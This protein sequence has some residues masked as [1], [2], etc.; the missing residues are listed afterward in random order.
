M[1]DELQSIYGFR[2]ADVSLFRA[3]RDELAER[4]GSLSLTRNFRGRKPLLDAVNAVFAQRFGDGYAPLEA[5]R[6]Q[7]V[8]SP[9]VV[10]DGEGRT[11]RGDASKSGWRDAEARRSSSC[12]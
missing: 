2:H 7:E 3:R 12:C 6:V 1:G 10:S 4:G 11:G 8:E 5:G 9:D